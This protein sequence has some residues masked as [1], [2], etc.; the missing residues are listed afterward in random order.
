MTASGVEIA[1]PVAGRSA[2]VVALV[3]TDGERSMLTDRAVAPSL[4]PDRSVVAGRRRPVP[5]AVLLLHLR[6]ARRLGSCAVPS[7][8]D[9]RIPVTI[10][11]SSVALLDGPDD[12]ARFTATVDEI[13]AAYV[14][15][16]D[17]E[18]AALDR[19]GWNDPGRWPAGVRAMIVKHG[20]APVEVRRRDVAPVRVPVVDPELRVAD[21]TGAGDA[22]AA[23]FTVALVTGASIEDAVA[24]GHRAAADQIAPRPSPAG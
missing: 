5:R 7:A 17:D 1:G 2:T 18:G 21:T 14:L 10:D 4:R 15:A 6:T 9:R 12:I 11:A 8:G 19:G 13:G 24:A 20:P 22:F 16:N 3:D 23:G